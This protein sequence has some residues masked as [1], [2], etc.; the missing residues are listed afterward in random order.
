MCITSE[1]SRGGV[2][3]LEF[4]LPVLSH[5]PWRSPLGTFG[6]PFLQEG[7]VHPAARQPPRP[8]PTPGA[9]SSL[10]QRDAESRCAQVLAE[11]AS[12]V[13]WGMW[14]KHWQYLLLMHSWKRSGNRNEDRAMLEML[15]GTERE[16]QIPWLFS[17]PPQFP[18]S[19]SH[20][21]NSGKSQLTQ[22]PRKYSL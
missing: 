20:Y 4:Y 13:G 15:P 3:K 7:Q 5:L 2:R 6:R 17:S 8:S 1:L 9:Y 11:D 22:E 14:I 19:A 16:G 18:A 12:R 10:R 21:L